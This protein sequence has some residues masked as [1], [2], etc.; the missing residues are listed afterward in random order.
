MSSISF[1]D[2]KLGSTRKSSRI[3]VRLTKLNTIVNWDKIYDLVK[4]MNS[5]NLLEGALTR[6]FY[7]K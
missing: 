5:M 7:Q 2:I 6:I 1:A 3:S 4:E